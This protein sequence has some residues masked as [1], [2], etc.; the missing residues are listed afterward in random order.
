M[1][2]DW[3]VGKGGKALFAVVVLTFVGD[4]VLTFFA[5]EDVDGYRISSHGNDAVTPEVVIA[6][7]GDGAV[8]ED[9]SVGGGASAGGFATGIRTMAS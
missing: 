3:E 7:M 9:D 2:G 8:V 1:T 5:F 4:A 6:S